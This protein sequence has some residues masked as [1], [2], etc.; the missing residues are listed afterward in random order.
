MSYIAFII[1]NFFSHG[2]WILRIHIV[3]L[4]KRRQFMYVY[5]AL[6]WFSHGL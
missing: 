6:F 3:R 2:P 1:R 5:N 4:F